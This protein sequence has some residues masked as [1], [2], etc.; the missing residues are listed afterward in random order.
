MKVCDESDF[1]SHPILKT[2]KFLVLFFG[3][4]KPWIFLVNKYL[5]A[6]NCKDLFFGLLVKG[7]GHH[8]HV[9]YMK[10]CVG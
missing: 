6:C 7:S 2:K 4:Y 8:Q 5:C 10:I 3:R 1:R 9:L